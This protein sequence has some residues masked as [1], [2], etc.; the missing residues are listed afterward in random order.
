[1]AVVGLMVGTNAFAVTGTFSISAGGNPLGYYDGYAGGSAYGSA[2]TTT[3]SDGKVVSAFRNADLGGV[4]VLYLTITGF[5]SNPGQSYLTGI[6]VS[7]CSYAPHTHTAA[8]AASYSYNPTYGAAT[9]S[10]VR[11]E[12]CIEY[13][14]GGH[15][16]DVT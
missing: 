11:N 9:W 8:S 10:W 14:F 1:M 13:L 6:D 7:F 5:T 3:L 12:V 16:V 2:S 4:Y 15:T